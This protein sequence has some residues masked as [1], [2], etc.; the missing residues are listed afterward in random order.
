[1]EGQ[2]H[3]VT[4]FYMNDSFSFV[5][6]ATFTNCGVVWCTAV[7]YDVFE[8]ENKQLCGETYLL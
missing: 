7:Y 4:C 5:F 3:W 6:A 1:M 2:I 8:L